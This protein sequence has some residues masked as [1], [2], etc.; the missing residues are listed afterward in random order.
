MQHSSG[1]GLSWV[2]LSWCLI[3]NVLFPAGMTKQ[4]SLDDRGDDVS[5]ISSVAKSIF[6]DGVVNWGR[7]ASLVAFG[8]VVAQ[9]MKDNGRRDCVD[10]VAQ[11]I[12]EYLL[13]DRRDWLIKN[14]GWV[15]SEG[16]EVGPTS[17]GG[18]ITAP[19]VQAACVI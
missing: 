12:S 17:C 11:E 1:S 7:I 14:N 3:P 8:A 2:C 19:I 5:F 9:Y 6:A 16:R 13:R 4:L 18:C 15:S 10:Q